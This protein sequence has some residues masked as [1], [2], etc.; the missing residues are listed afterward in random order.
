ME[1]R[2]FLIGTGA[3]AAGGAAALGSGAFSRV[4]SQR[5]VTIQTANDAN[6]YLGLK[7]LDTPN[8]NNF[9]E[10][11]EG[12]LRIDIG[13]FG[14]DGD[15]DY[16]TGVG[17]NSDSFTWFDGM[18]EICNQG[19]API[20]SLYYTLP[21]GVPE[22]SYVNSP[23]EDPDARPGGDSP[24]TVPTV[25]FYFKREDSGERVILEPYEYYG[26]SEDVSVTELDLGNCEEVGVRTVTKGISSPSTLIDGDVV[27]TA[28][29]PAAG[30]SESD[31]S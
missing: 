14:A 6:A 10:Y 18:F 27:L 22:N 30:E 31:G 7:T 26:N 25:A 15:Y 23:G 4:E 24:E 20:E 9:A 21:D 5:Q 1:R 28:D 29:A 16:E 3:L 13:D 8:S 12:H 17:V 11:D 19:K 2:K